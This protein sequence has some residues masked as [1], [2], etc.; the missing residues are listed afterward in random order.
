MTQWVKKLT[1][2]HEDVD[3]IPGLKE[4]TQIW[5]CCGCGV[6]PSPGTQYAAGT[7]LK[8]NFFLKGNVGVLTPVPQN[9]ILLVKIKS[10]W[11]R[12]GPQSNM[13]NALIKRG[14]LDPDIQGNTES[15]GVMMP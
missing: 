10:Y 13:T 1:S 14:N 4:A 9:V 12:V 8:K 7:A 3:L 6:V 2:I 11:R 15:V 5:C